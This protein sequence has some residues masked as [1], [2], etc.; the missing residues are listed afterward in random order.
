MSAA[1]SQ[2]T[3]VRAVIV[4]AMES[5]FAPLVARGSLTGEAVEL[6]RAR[7][8]PATLAGHD[9]LLV[10][11][12]IGLVNAAVATTVALQQ[13]ETSLVVSVGS[14]GGFAGAVEIGQVAVGS[15]HR[16]HQAD[17]VAFGYALGQVPGMPA[18]FPSDPA[19]LAAV[20]DMP[21]VVVGPHASADVFVAGHRIEAVQRDFPG[22]VA[23]EMEATAIAQVAHTFGVGF[24]SVRGISDLCGVDAAADH[25][26]TV[27]KVSAA[28]ADVVVRVLQGLVSALCP[29]RTSPDTPD[30]A[31]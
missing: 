11:S 22:T 8:Q 18:F 17:A 9:V 26:A 15:E 10:R 29:R 14:A 19:A 7:L 13:V 23:V 6:G 12:G 27:E 28:A 16:Y 20:G 24:V 25:E 5:E 1:S 30:A 3:S 21:G 2:R 31:G 4:A